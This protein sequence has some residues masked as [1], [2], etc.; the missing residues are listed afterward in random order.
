MKSVSFCESWLQACELGMSRVLCNKNCDGVVIR[1][2]DFR[3]LSTQGLWRHFILRKRDT[4]M[5]VQVGKV[6]NNLPIIFLDQKSANNKFKKIR[7]CSIFH[8][9]WRYFLQ[10]FFKEFVPTAQQK[11]LSTIWLPRISCARGFGELFQNDG[12][13]KLSS[14]CRK[15]CLPNRLKVEVVEVSSKKMRASTK[16]SALCLFVLAPPNTFLFLMRKLKI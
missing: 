9:L 13:R 14:C 16:R 6:Q 8:L 15:N 7:V 12:S 5:I 4:E 10:D 1:L 3:F 2:I 11:I